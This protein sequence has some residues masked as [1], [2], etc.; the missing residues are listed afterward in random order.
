MASCRSSES[1]FPSAACHV[2]C[3]RSNDRHRKLGEPSCKIISAEIVAIDFFTVPTIRLRV[4]FVFLVMQHER[5]RVLHFGVTQRPTAN[6]WNLA[7]TALSERDSRLKLCGFLRYWVLPE[8]SHFT[9]SNERKKRSQVSTPQRGNL[10]LRNL[11]A[12]IHASSQP[13]SRLR[14]Q[15]LGELRYPHWV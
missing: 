6:Q 4:L 5:R 14:D 7:K 13:S 2:S 3:E 11:R 12:G 1:W 8:S 9:A 15:N 10:G